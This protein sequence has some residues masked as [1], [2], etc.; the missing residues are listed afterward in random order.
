MEPSKNSKTEEINFPLTQSFQGNKLQEDKYDKYKELIKDLDSKLT[1]F[2]DQQKLPDNLQLDKKNLDPQNLQEL[3]NVLSTELLGE[4]VHIRNLSSEQLI[5]ILMNYGCLYGRTIDESLQIRLA[6]KCLFQDL[7]P[8]FEVPDKAI[9]DIEKPHIIA[10]EFNSLKEIELARN[11][12]GAVEFIQGIPIIF[13]ASE[14]ATNKESMAS[15][16]NANTKLVYGGYYHPKGTLVLRSIFQELSEDAKNFFKNDENLTIDKVKEFFE[17]FGTLVPTEIVVGGELMRKEEV[18]Q[19][20]QSSNEVRE[21]DR[22]GKILGLVQTWLLSIGLSAQK[23]EESRASSDHI[24]QQ[25]H[26]E[27]NGGDEKYITDATKWINSL[28]N[29]DTWRVIRV[30]GWRY[31]YEYLQPKLAEQIKN[32]IMQARQE[33]L[34]KLKQ[35]PLNIF[36]YPLSPNIILKNRAPYALCAFQNYLF[37]FFPHAMQI[38]QLPNFEKSVKVPAPWKYVKSVTT[39]KN[40]IYASTSE[41]I[42]KINPQTSEVTLIRLENREIQMCLLLSHGNY[43]YAFLDK[44]FKINPE[45]G[46]LEIFTPSNW[47]TASCGIVIKDFAYV[48]LGWSGNLW[49][50]D[51]EDKSEKKISRSWGNSQAMISCLENDEHVLIYHKKLYKLD[52]NNGDYQQVEDNQ[53]PNMLCATTTGTEM[54]V[55]TKLDPYEKSQEKILFYKVKPNGARE[56]LDVEWSPLSS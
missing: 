27:A 15:N 1:E 24:E 42:F 49:R 20:A 36:N 51:L 28:N 56:R 25:L 10:K 47:D 31:T 45:T 54:Y 13:N 6:D 7:P 4:Y 26:F 41:G 37:V 38:L 43:L 40:F 30:Q 19:E 53:Y 35:E 34:N 39:L 17:V 5:K 18:K 14:D 12:L 29:T 16:K 11:G 48:V 22:K 2:I 8:K 21:K 46:N 3:L 33:E 9:V 23:K 55:A 50:L 52:V 32:I 44:V